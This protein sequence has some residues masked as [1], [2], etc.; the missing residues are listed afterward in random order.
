[1]KP[2]YAAIALN[3]TPGDW[4]GNQARILRAIAEAKAQNATVLLFP[5]LC[6]T[7]YDCED[8]FLSPDTERKAW[9]ILTE[10]L[11]HTQ[12]IIVAVGLPFTF[13]RKCYNAVVILADGL[14]QGIHPKRTLA[15][16]GV[17]YEPRWFEAWPSD[18]REEL[19]YE[20]RNIP[21]GASITRV[22]DL[23][24]AVETCMEAWI[25]HRFIE[26]LTA[27]VVL[28]ASASHFALDKLRRRR[29]L[30][31]AGS[32][33]IN[34]VYVLT[35]QLGNIGGKLIYDGQ[36]LIA[37]KGKI[38]AEGA[39]FSFEE[40]TILLQGAGPTLSREAQA[41]YAIALGLKDY[42]EKSRTQG[43]WVVSVSGGI[44]SSL[45]IILLCLA[46]ALSHS[47]WPIYGLYQATRQSSQATFE[48]ARSL[49]Q[50]LGVIFYSI[51]I[52]GL[53]SENLAKI[54]PLIHKKF[55]WEEDDLTLQNIQARVR[56]PLGWLLANAIEALYVTTGNRS[57]AF[58]G[59]CTVD[60]DTAGGVAP[61]A[62]LDKAFLIGL[63]RFWLKEG[64]IPLGP[65]TA[66]N[67]V[68]AM[69]PTAELRPA[70][71][72]Q[73]DENDLMPYEILATLERA[74]IGQHLSKEDTQALLVWRYPYIE[75]ENLRRYLST[76]Y[77]R[78]HQSAW[79]RERLAVGFVVD[80]VNACPRAGLRFP[81]LSCVV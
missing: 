20:G 75:L 61:L 67:G 76:F 54:A 35:N 11:P 64:L 46:R 69:P 53:V 21:I 55:N 40:K 23:N 59:Y 65:I 9:G 71:A 44:D 49:C 63:S 41:S 62:G 81:V 29:E 7:S 32:R 19:L 45:T 26:G 16:F 12:N 34:G 39:P 77:A 4:T 8:L 33:L 14:I 22:H 68:L 2:H 50:S 70:T 28:N 48:A 6:I 18:K 5:E 56:A 74:V 78:L 30:A 17:Y 66:L 43:G 51:D 47:N 36:T 13:Q 60:G 37:D 80:T 1:M 10:I 58:M 52:E 57:E 73:T 42:Y 27:D 25:P 72:Q 3:Q 79:K 24:I 38:I 15:K 31:E